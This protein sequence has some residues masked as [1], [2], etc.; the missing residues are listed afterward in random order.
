[1]DLH[2]RAIGCLLGQAIGDALGTLC[3][4]DSSKVAQRKVDRLPRPL[5]LNPGTKHLSITDDTEMTLALARSLIRHKGYEVEDV[6]QSYVTWFKS[7]SIDI[8]TAT[9]RAFE[10]CDLRFSQQTNY[11]LVTRSA[12]KKNS[13]TLSNGCLMRVSPLGIASLNWTDED[14]HRICRLDCQ[15]TNPHPVAQEAVTTY[16][17]SIKTGLMT[18]QISEIIDQVVTPLPDQSV[19][20]QTIL[21]SIETPKVDQIPMFTGKSVTTDSTFQ[22]YLGIALYNTFY[23]L[24]HTDDYVESTLNIMR[25]GGDTDTNLAIFSSLYG[26]IHGYTKI[27]PNLID[28]ILTRPYPRAQVYPWGETHDLAQVALRLTNLT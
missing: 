3:E 10:N 26:A 28:D 12:H 18:G 11:Q 9:Q 20:R 15:L 16:V 2:T 24:T 8:G 17:L 21:A 4:F 6:T 23:E 25:R 1:M 5:S 14:L 13:L 7:G 19:I 22:G 27:P